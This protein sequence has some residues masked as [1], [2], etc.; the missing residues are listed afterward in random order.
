[1]KRFKITL[2]TAKTTLLL[3][4]CLVIS[5][6]A[7]SDI[8]KTITYQGYLT[9]PQGT[10]VDDTI[11][12]TFSLYSQLSGGAALWTE[13]QDVTVVD[14]SFSI[15]LGS[16]NNIDLPFD[17]QYYLGITVGMD[18]EMTPRQALNSAGY[19]FRAKEADSVKDNAVT[20]TVIA[21]DAVTTDK[22]SDDAI[23]ET[24]I[25]SGAVG[26][27]AIANGAVSSTQIGDN[28][29]NTQDLSDNAVTVNKIS[30]NIISSIDQV[31]N[32]GGDIDLIAGTNISIQSDDIADTI[33][34]SA[35]NGE[36]SLWTED[37]GNVYRSTGNVGIGTTNP[38]YR[39]SFGK[40]L[41]TLKK[42]ALWDDINDF[43][44]FGVDT[45]R[46]TF[47]TNDTEKMTILGNGNIG[48]GTSS[49]DSKL[50]VES[51][52]GDALI[53]INQTGAPMWAGLR[54][55]RSGTE[56]WF[57]GMSEVTNDLLFRRSSTSNDLV[58]TTS[59]DIGV[60]GVGSN[61]KFNVETP[62][63]ANDYI[64]IFG[65]HGA[66]GNYGLIGNSGYG[67]YGYGSLAGIYGQ[68]DGNSGVSGH[69]NTGI[70]VFGASSSSYGVY[71]QSLNPNAYAG[72]F[73][74]NV[75]ITGQLT[76]GNGAFKIDHPLDPGNKYLSHSFVESPEMMNVYNGNTVL[77]ENGEGWV[78]LPEWFESLNKSFRYQLTPI[79]APGPNLYIAEEITENQFKIAGGRLGMKVSWQ[80]TG[81][82]QDPYAKIHPIKV[83]EEKLPED[84]G[85]YLH[86]EAYG[87]PKEKGIGWAEDPVMIK[88]TEG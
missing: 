64:C 23:S 19:A 26:A 51:T 9:D 50:T 13:S 81:I 72:Y 20:S 55:A 5:S 8:P 65:K 14:G 86:P 39:L 49:P 11:H 22:I 31:S 43:Y 54:L 33:T 52:G 30:P 21:N 4:L 12:I 41:F 2:I 57:I 37:G 76:K 35:T 36:T 75:L 70:G 45:G 18:N 82:R 85:Y 34:I 28:S 59:G 42:I 27:N 87:Q 84:Q 3:I 68:S 60:G 88:Q 47:F 67:V 32:D 10:S 53:N 78:E 66:S 29:I 24:K 15:N 63:S 69:S 44:G 46:L 38:Q 48:I 62:Q 79:G 74:G 7:L 17:V 77:N 16:V 80:V 71:G 25:A 73:N 6:P 58:V 83:E 1:M 61:K 40:D 56:R